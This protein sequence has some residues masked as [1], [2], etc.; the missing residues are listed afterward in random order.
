M[1]SVCNIQILTLFDDQTESG[2]PA[3]DRESSKSVSV[4]NYPMNV[5]DKD[6]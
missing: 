3:I 5:F 1:E 6:T 2:K 4:R